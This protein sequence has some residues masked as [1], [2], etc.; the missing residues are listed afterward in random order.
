MTLE[1]F[2]A[3]VG[4]RAPIVGDR[5]FRLDAIGYP[6]PGAISVTYIFGGLKD[7]LS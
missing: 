5:N 3:H 4:A 2:L 6:D 7:V 1:E